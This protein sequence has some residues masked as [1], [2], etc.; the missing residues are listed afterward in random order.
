MNKII[1]PFLLGV[2]VLLLVHEAF[3][4]SNFPHSSAFSRQQKRSA[5]FVANRG[6]GVLPQRGSNTAGIAPPPT[7]RSIQSSPSPLFSIFGTI[8]LGDLFY[9]D[10]SMAFSAWEWI[11]NMGAPAALIG[12]AVLVTLSE[13]REALS[14]R[15]NDVKW[16][17]LA[18]LSMRYLLLSSFA[19]EVVCIFVG[20]ITGSV[21]LGHGPQ[22]AA[23]MAGYQS[24]LQLLH[25]HHELEYLTTQICF[26]QGLFNWLGAVAIEMILPRPTET[27]TARRMN[28]C[29]A[30]WLV[31][32]MIWMLAFYNNHLSFYSDYL[33][34]LRRFVALFLQDYFLGRPWR[35]L[36]LLY[37]PAFAA[38]SILTWKAFSSPPE[39]DED[40]TVAEEANDK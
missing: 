17:R 32:F 11:S 22:A 30:G 8:E 5:P 16:I 25:H 35:P 38:S 2:F 3:G 15:K 27:R 34:M 19:L 7:T 37:G 4:F 10:A 6:N 12:G 40:V 23:K 24:P 20:T 39:D 9:D 18:K 31:S 21:L 1:R 36:S 33:S 14:P 26:L 28:K 13:T 29:L